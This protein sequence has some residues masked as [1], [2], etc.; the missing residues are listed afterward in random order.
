MAPRDPHARRS[1]PGTEHCVDGH[2]QRTAPVCSCRGD[3][4]REVGDW[5]AAARQ[6]SSSS[7]SLHSSPLPPGSGHD[8]YPHIQIVLH[9]ADNPRAPPLPTARGAASGGCARDRHGTWTRRA[10]QRGRW[11]TARRPSPQASCAPGPCR[12]VRPR[13]DSCRG[14]PLGWL[15][16]APTR[17]CPPPAQP[18]TSERPVRLGAGAILR[19]RSPGTSVRGSRAP[20]WA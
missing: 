16:M 2:T 3:S 11:L 8:R 15:A 19:R 12:R 18:R 14:L 6:A 7:P 17:R 4:G 1:S 5:L 13:L 9:G 10:R 20:G